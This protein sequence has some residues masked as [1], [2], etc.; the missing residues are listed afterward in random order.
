MENINKSESNSIKDNSTEAI[1]L[2]IE[3]EKWKIEKELESKKAFYRDF[4]EAQVNMVFA[5]KN[6]KNPAFN[7]SPYSNL[8]SVIEAFKQSYAP[9][10]FSFSQ[11]PSFTFIENDYDSLKDYMT[12]DSIHNLLRSPKNNQVTLLSV[13]NFFSPKT[14]VEIKTVLYHKD[15]YSISNITKSIVNDSIAIVIASGITYLK[16]YGLQALIGQPSE[17]DDGTLASNL[18]ESSITL[19]EVRSFLLESEIDVALAE[20]IHAELLSKKKTHDNFK[21][22]ILKNKDTF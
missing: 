18:K 12:D 11:F 5:K 13:K 4:S 16:R 22:F 17:D 15:G 1:K 2:Q 14:L 3:F 20:K 10:G 7:N 9:K 19:E 21:E 6:A 8:E